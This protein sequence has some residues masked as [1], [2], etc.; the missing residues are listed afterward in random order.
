MSGPGPLV[1]V[2]SASAEQSLLTANALG[3]ALGI[4]NVT[5]SSTKYGRTFTVGSG[6]EKGKLDQL[7]TPL[8]LATSAGVYVISWPTFLHL[9]ER[10]PQV[11]NWK[12][13]KNW[14]HRFGVT[15]LCRVAGGLLGVLTWSSLDRCSTPQQIVIFATLSAGCGTLM[16][17]GRRP[18]AKTEQK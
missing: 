6:H 3:T 16:Y 13:N 11:A 1:T 2:L 8:Q 14:A 17:L 12:K 5:A 18:V 7:K 10:L 4:F 15:G 9:M